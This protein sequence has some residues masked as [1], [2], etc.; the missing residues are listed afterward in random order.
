MFLLK[1]YAH[2]WRNSKRWLLLYS[3]A[4]KIWCFQLSN[5]SLID[6]A[7]ITRLEVLVTEQ[8]GFGLADTIVTLNFNLNYENACIKST[9]LS[10][11][12]GKITFCG[13]D[14]HSKGVYLMKIPFTIL[15]EHQQPHHIAADYLTGVLCYNIQS[16]SSYLKAISASVATTIENYL[17]GLVNLRIFCAKDDII[18]K[19]I[20]GDIAH[21]FSLNTKLQELYVS[22]NN[23]Q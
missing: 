16:K 3:E 5:C 19:E 13:S 11:H 6:N 4:E 8:T 2:T 7:L 18:S 22:G 14:M 10:H 9:V 20:S 1:Y 21:I 23:L 17:P 12:I 15:Q